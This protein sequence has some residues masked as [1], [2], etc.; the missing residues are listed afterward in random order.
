MLEIRAELTCDKCGKFYDSFTV[1]D[2]TIE[3]DAIDNLRRLAK[4]DGWDTAVMNFATYD[5]QDFCPGCAE[6]K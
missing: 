2:N 6:D 1:Y 4:A 3:Q 5:L